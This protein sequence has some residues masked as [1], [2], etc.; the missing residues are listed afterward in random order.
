MKSIS[1]A[2]GIVFSGDTKKLLMIRRRGKWDLPKGKIEKHENPLEAAVREVMEEC[3][4]PKPEVT[5]LHAQTTHHYQEGGQEVEKTTK[6]F[7]MILPIE[8]KGFPQTEEEIE[9]V[10]WVSRKEAEQNSKDTYQNIRSLLES[11]TWPE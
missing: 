3:G 10:V 5:G 8:S 7:N 2:G 11:L 6:W 1:A 4:I 9:K